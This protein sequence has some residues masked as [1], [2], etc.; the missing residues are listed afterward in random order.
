[1]TT[2]PTTTTATAA[3]VELGL[4]ARLAL[5][6]ALMDERLALA[7]IAFEVDTA[8]LP[9][10]DP[11]P[12]VTAPPPIEPA[13]EPCPYSTPAAATLHRARIRLETAG[14]CTGQ[15][16][17][18]QGAA[19]AIGAIRAA[20]DSRSAAD[21]ACAVLLEAVQR[22]FAHVQTIPS[23]NDGQTQPRLILL[24]LDRAAALADARGQ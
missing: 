9:A 13:A 21:D 17:D 18:E 11:I 8:H 7:N 3:P 24:Y 4:D 6:G 2:A 5:V 22:D 20:A 12:N 15:L 10:A 23:W 1:M 14:W 16:R 19:C